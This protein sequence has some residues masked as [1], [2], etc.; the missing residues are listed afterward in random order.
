MSSRSVGG[1]LARASALVLSLCAL[2]GTA[3]A[4]TEEPATATIPTPLIAEIRDWATKPVVLI[5][6]RSQNGKHAGL[7]QAEIDRL[8]QQ[9]RAETSAAERPLIAQLMGSPLST[10]LTR[11]KANSHGLYTEIFVMDDKGLSVGQSSITSD[12]WQGDE[13]KWLKS[14]GA[15]PDALE[16]GPV[17]FDEETKSR[18]VQVSLPIVDPEGG[19]PIGAVT[20]EIDLDELASR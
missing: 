4:Q 9:W 7:A 5:S 20:A 3:V 15:G 13:D 2:S 16:I 14:F 10:Y 8:D 17:E 18:R 6:V 19:I 11:I 12:Y 1:G